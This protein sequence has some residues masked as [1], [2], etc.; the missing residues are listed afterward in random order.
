[1]QLA[2]LFAASL[3][4]QAGD[5]AIEVDTAGGSVTLTFGE[6]DARSNRLA[7]VLSGRGLRPGD[8]VAV[9]LANRL[10]FTSWPMPSPGS[11]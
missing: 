3:L 1:M 11:W 10:E 7:R 8:R 2:D 6:L 5:P 9:Y 4:G